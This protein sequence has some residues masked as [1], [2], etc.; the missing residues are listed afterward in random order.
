MILSQ[1]GKAHN[2]IEIFK[3]L[4]HNIPEIRS[5]VRFYALLAEAAGFMLLKEKLDMHDDRIDYITQILLCQPL[6]NGSNTLSI[7]ALKSRLGIEPEIQK[8]YFGQID[9]TIARNHIS[10][11]LSNLVGSLS[12]EE[13]RMDAFLCVIKNNWNCSRFFY[14]NNKDKN[15]DALTSACN[16]IIKNNEWHGFDPQTLYGFIRAVNSI[17]QDRADILINEIS[18]KFNNKSLSLS[19][20]IGLLIYRNNK[21]HEL[22]EKLSA[23]YGGSLLETQKKLNV[24]VCISGQ[25]RGYHGCL[26]ALIDILGLDEHRYRVFVHTWNNIGRK[27]PVLANSAKRAFDGEFFITYINVFRGKKDIEGYIESSYPNFYS[28]LVNCNQASLERL[29]EYYKTDDIVIEKEES[30]QFSSWGNQEKMHYKIYAAH[31]LAVNCGENFDLEI[32]IRPDC[33]ISAKEKINLQDIYKLSKSNLSVFTPGGLSNNGVW[34]TTM[35]HDIFAIGVP[36]AMSAYTD[37]YKD[38]K[39]FVSNNAFDY[40]D[41]FM[42]HVTIEHNLF[43]NGVHIDKTVGGPL[44]DPEKLSKED[45]YRSLCED[46]KNRS[47]THEDHLLIE[48]C[49]KDM[50]LEKAI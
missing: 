15:R 38:S 2:T 30:E 16:K 21:R 27:F 19:N 31:N 28:L 7:Q 9:D 13:E 8:Q 4:E 29:R 32:R 42:G 33:K 3:D 10:N 37:T 18:L 12:S 11:I 43:A 41:F 22:F 1:P 23:R 45:I 49:K 44:L 24:A 50:E 48:A 14:G 17:D 40:P 35:I 34:K 36:E 26:E 6:E 20:P 46:I 47:P 39:F 5:D 25:L